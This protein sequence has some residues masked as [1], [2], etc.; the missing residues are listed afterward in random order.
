MNILI[1]TD[2]YPPMRTSGAVHI[3]DLAQAFIQS[4][5]KVTILIP[6]STQSEKVVSQFD[7]GV[8]VIRIK[9]FQTKDVAYWKRLLAELINPYVMW[10]RLQERPELLKEQINGVVWYSPT[11]FWGPLIKRLKKHFHAKSY[12]ILRDIFP[13]WANDLGLIKKGPTLLFLKIVETYQYRQAN[14]IGVQSPNNLQYFIHEHPGLRSK[15]QVLWNWGAKSATKRPCSI[16]LATSSLAGK[17]ICIYA[18]NMGVAQ[19]IEVLFELAISL[20]NDPY[21][22]FVFVG[23]G[24]EVVNLRARIKAENLTNVLLFDEIDYEEIP[25]LYAQCDIGLLSLDVRHRTHNI[26]GKLITYLQAGLPIFGFVNPENDVIRI[27]QESNIGFVTDTSDLTILK[28]QLLRLSK[29]LENDDLMPK[30]CQEQA[31]ILFS[32]DT[33]R[34]QVKSALDVAF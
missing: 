26:P 2:A 9:A 4:G 23:R 17:S 7:Q 13:D 25:S 21:L 19:G 14:T 8:Q 34:N 18:G 30:R 28:T 15:T 16:N 31:R 27:T 1:V 5:S 12:L 10:H 24:S 6:D 3:Y 22:G 29:L 32:V 33:A 11:I 20:K